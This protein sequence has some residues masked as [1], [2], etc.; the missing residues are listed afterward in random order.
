MA[1]LARGRDGPG[2]PSAISSS[3]KKFK[4]YNIRVFPI[5]GMGREVAI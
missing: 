5:L 3:S 2:P 1:A 4:D